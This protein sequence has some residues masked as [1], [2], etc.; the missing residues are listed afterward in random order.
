MKSESEIILF[1]LL[2]LLTV[3]CGADQKVDQS[4]LLSNNATENNNC[5]ALTVSSYFDRYENAL[6][7][8]SDQKIQSLNEKYSTFKNVCDTQINILTQLLEER[9][10]SSLLQNEICNKSLREAKEKLGALERNKKHEVSA[11][12][13]KKLSTGYY[14]ISKANEKTNWFMASKFCESKGLKL[15][16][17]ESEAENTA[18]VGAI[19][20][21]NENYWLSGTDL[22]SEG[23]FY[24]SATGKD[25]KGFTFYSRGQPDNYKTNEHCLHFWIDP[26]IKP[27]VLRWNDYTCGLPCRFI[28]VDCESN[29]EVDLS[30]LSNSG[31]GSCPSVLAALDKYKEDHTAFCNHKVQ[32]MFEKYEAQKN[33]C[34]WRVNLLTK[35][36]EDRL[37][38]CF[39]ERILEK[40]ICNLT[41]DK[42]VERK[43]STDEG[44]LMKMLQANRREILTENL[45]GLSTGN[46]FISKPT[47]K[48]NWYLAGQFCKSNGLEL[49]SIETEAENIA[50]VEALGKTT[51][52]FW[53][54]GTDLGSEGKFYWSVTGKNIGLFSDFSHGQ[55]DNYKKN[56]HCLQL[57]TNTPNKTY[58]WNDNAPPTQQQQQSLHNLTT[59][60]LGEQVAGGWLVNDDNQRLRVIKSSK[61]QNSLPE[62]EASKMLREAWNAP[63]AP[64]SCDTIVQE[65][66]TTTTTTTTTTRRRLPSAPEARLRRL[67]LAAAP[68]AQPQQQPA[69]RPVSAPAMCSDSVLL[70]GD[71]GTLMPKNHRTP[72]YCHHSQVGNKEQMQ[73]HFEFSCRLNIDDMNY[74]YNYIENEYFLPARIIP[75]FSS[76]PRTVSML[77]NTSKSISSSDEDECRSLADSLEDLSRLN[78]QTSFDDKLAH[79]GTSPALPQSQSPTK[80]P[81]P[82]PEKFFVNL[83]DQEDNNFGL[84]L[85]DFLREKLEKRRQELENKKPK[86]MEPLQTQRIRTPRLNRARRIVINKFNQFESIPEENLDTN[87]RIKLARTRAMARNY[88][89]RFQVGHSQ[90][91]L[92]GIVQE[93]KDLSIIS[94]KV[95]GKEAIQSVV[96]LPMPRVKGRELTELAASTPGWGNFYVIKGD[97]A[98]AINAR[99]KGDAPKAKSARKKWTKVETSSSEERITTSVRMHNSPA[100]QYQSRQQRAVTSVSK[101]SPALPRLSSGL[102]GKSA[103]SERVHPLP[104]LQRHARVPAIKRRTPASA[105]NSVALPSLQSPTADDSSVR[106]RTYTRSRSGKERPSPLSP[107]KAK[108]SV[109]KQTNVISKADIEPGTIVAEAGSTDAGTWSVTLSDGEEAVDENPSPKGDKESHRKSPKR[110]NNQNSRV[111]TPADGENC[112]NYIINIKNG[113]EKDVAHRRPSSAVS[114]NSNRP[115]RPNSAGSP[116]S[117]SKALV[118]VSKAIVPHQTEMPLTTSSAE[119]MLMWPEMQALIQEQ[120][121]RHIKKQI[122]TVTRSETMTTT[123]E[124]AIMVQRLRGGE[125][126]EALTF[127]PDLQPLE[128]SN[129][130]V[131]TQRRKR[132]SS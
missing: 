7:K 108:V 26:F 55:P 6:H 128:A 31:C 127:S 34:D 78:S 100:T 48:G 111:P 69:N 79:G 131:A 93:T 121:T 77:A 1:I 36:F 95:D 103:S 129:T 44:T 14:Y 75:R 118:P 106:F 8:L 117:K 9:Q 22:G 38:S 46:Y 67:F 87:N 112:A 65:T 56:E 122:T 23:K 21:T 41:I 12:G 105:Q 57:W 37:N 125:S 61:D 91:A 39:R 102:G 72:C 90:R 116:T 47:Q 74:N 32:S 27:P 115:S 17:I 94:P 11:V 83:K 70:P 16:S 96:P 81:L 119:D 73:Q 35:M 107:S 2:L 51:D 66:V 62:A 123:T 13:L 53:I 110:Q 3:V 10:I 28:F 85:P 120:M 114:V 132:A 80:P 4:K 63:R 92:Q 29:Q 124:G 15:V 5:D 101:S 68:T 71:A 50:L 19:G 30:Y 33:V 97:E 59:E 98:V 24:W 58:A 60:E 109:V 18:I 86:S 88:Q 43:Y 25:I 64:P 20:N 52:C 45:L 99:D 54:S 130:V 89:P 82:K 76:L 42:E 113:G 40:E 126:T 104:N 49:V 84:Q